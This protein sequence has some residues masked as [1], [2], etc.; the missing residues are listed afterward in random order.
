MS[1][2]LRVTAKMINLMPRTITLRIALLI[3]IVLIANISLTWIF[4]IQY[5]K[6]LQIKETIQGVR[7]LVSELNAKESI[8]S[9][10]DL[11]DEYH[12]IERDFSPKGLLPANYP[13]LH[14]MALR[15]NAVNEATIEFHNSSSEPNYVWL[16]YDYAPHDYD[17]W[18]GIP[19]EAFIE[20]TPYVAF[21]Q[22]FIIIFLVALGSI[23]IARSIRKPLRDIALATQKFGAGEIPEYIKEVGPV[24]VVQ[25]A[26]SFNRMLDDFK[27]LQ[28]ERELMLA[29]IS[30]DLRTPLTRL[31]LSV[32]MTKSLDHET[33]TDMI[34]DIEQIT[35]MQQQFIDYVSAGGNEKFSSINMNELIGETIMR[36][37]DHVSPPIQFEQAEQLIF[38][39]VAPLCISRVLNNLLTNAIKYGKPPIQVKLEQDNAFTM[40][41]VQD[42][43]DGVPAEQVSDIF[44]PL[45]RGDVARSNAQGSGLGLAI[46][47]RIVQKHHG[48]IS[49][50]QSENS[51]EIKILLPTLNIRV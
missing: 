12:I 36:F 21:A 35:A 10:T 43:G 30:H 2:S 47:E 11:L 48:K 50:N 27:T 8:S 39:E 23:F 38:A 22:E 41:T 7:A 4:S 5:S 49:L 26:Q 51:F 33:R 32:E 34:Q 19:K 20:G 24:E 46:V 42:K 37:N 1:L 3:F 45:F 29:G 17:I 25:V 31:Q 18:L 9:S 15:F 14:A 28:R 6:K 16:H 40:I 44:R 13:L